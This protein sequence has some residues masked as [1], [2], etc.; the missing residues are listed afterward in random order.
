MACVICYEDVPA[1]ELT[2][3]RCPN[4]ADNLIAHSLCLNQWF[5]HCF[6]QHWDESCPLC[7]TTIGNAYFTGAEHHLRRAP[8]I[9]APRYNNPHPAYL[10]SYIGNEQSLGLP[11]V[12]LIPHDIR[13]RIDFVPLDQL[14]VRY[15]EDEN[16]DDEDGDS[17]NTPAA[18]ST[19]QIDTDD[20]D[21]GGSFISED[22]AQ[23]LR[24]IPLHTLVDRI[25]EEPEFVEAML[26]WAILQA[27][28]RRM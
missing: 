4:C 5:E 3:E 24:E 2:N 17:S 14:T 16:N 15:E 23:L 22:V 20:E 6:E 21:D 1:D 9:A 7:R 8:A 13:I 10:P 18:A 26:G 28:S 19:N 25:E 11:E 12:W 27:Q